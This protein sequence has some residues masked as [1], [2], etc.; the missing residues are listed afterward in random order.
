MEKKVNWDSIPSLEGLEVDWDYEKKNV[1]DKRAFVRLDLNDM[2]QLFEVNE[3]PVKVATVQRV[4]QGTLL[5]LSTGGAAVLLNTSLDQGQALKIGFILNTVRVLA[6]GQVR[7]VQHLEQ[8]YKLGIQFVDLDPKI[9]E[10][11]GGLYAS[12]VFR[13]AY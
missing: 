12:K 5:D 9:G 7:H 11:I 1:R 2:G 6:K 13:H 8:G 10:F 4:L 3:I